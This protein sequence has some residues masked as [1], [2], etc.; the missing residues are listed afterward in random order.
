MTFS[1]RSNHLLTKSGMLCIQFVY[2]VTERWPT[3]NSLVSITEFFA[4]MILS[5]MGF[6]N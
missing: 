6:Y 1:K 5:V 2:L 3:F 4:Y